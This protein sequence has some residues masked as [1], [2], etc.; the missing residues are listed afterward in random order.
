MSLTRIAVCLQFRKPLRGDFYT[1]D[2]PYPPLIEPA[3]TLTTAEQRRYAR[4]LAL[5]GFGKQAQ[6][7]LRNASVLVLGAGGLGAPALTYLAA[8]G[9]GRIAVID[10][11]SVAE[12]NLHRQV[13]H[14]TNDVGR[15]K[16]ESVAE[17]L[18]RVNPCVEVVQHPVPLTS[19]NSDALI[20][21]H[22]VVLDGTDNFTARYD[23]SDAAT[24]A[25]IP[26]IWAS[27]NRFE[28]QLGVL[29]A[30][31]GPCYRC[32]FPQPPAP[33][34]VPSCAD[35]GVLGAVPGVLGTLQAVEAIKLICGIGEPLVGR[36]QVHD[37][38]QSK[39]DEVQVGADPTCASCGTGQDRSES[40]GGWTATQLHRELQRNDALLVVDVREAE[41]RAV[42][43]IPGS[44]WL[45]KDEL[46]AGRWR[47]LPQDQPLVLYCRSG[48]R[49]SECLALLQSQGY[50]QADH[51][52]GG[53]RAWLVEVTPDMSTG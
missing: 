22:H 53:I 43:H 29:W 32:L 23:V 5:S 2:M 14:G 16:V 9:V 50:T 31:R 24:R 46:L 8:A 25:G 26:H 39:V 51:L 44:R 38:L 6:L 10:D 28:G 47:E 33:G 4:H 20:A 41:E 27:V 15:P 37:L 52:L 17:A 45:P 18:A 36:I 30:G 48:I 49:S 7:R 13:I 21:G 42:N 1:A 3:S 40:I 12:S 34:V 11:D 19:A 35:A